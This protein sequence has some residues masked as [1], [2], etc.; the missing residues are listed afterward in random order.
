MQDFFSA[1]ECKAFAKFIDKLPLELT[2][3][4]KR[5][6]AERVNREFG[7]YFIRSSTSLRNPF[8]L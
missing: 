2:P 4:K 5:G 3:P 6:E 7:R 1:T 8:D